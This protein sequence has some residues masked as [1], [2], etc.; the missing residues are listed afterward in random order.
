MKALGPCCSW[1][2]FWNYGFVQ[3]WRDKLP[4]VAI[5]SFIEAKARHYWR[6]YAMT[7]WEA[8]KTI[9]GAEDLHAHGK[10]ASR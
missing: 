9:E 10:G 7:G 6:V 3:Y 4:G 8:W 1:E 2:T 5:P